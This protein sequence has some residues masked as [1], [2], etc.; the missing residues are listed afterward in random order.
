MEIPLLKEIVVVLGI[1]IFIILGFQKLKLPSILG[2]LLAGIIVGPS[3]FNLLSS[4]H[5]VELLSEIG[6]IFLLFVIGI[7]LSF[8]GLMKMRRIVFLGGGVQVIGTILLTSLVVYA[9][10]ISYNTAIFIGFLI[11][12]S[13]TA[14]VLKM[15]QERGEISQSHGRLALGILIFQDIIVVPMMLLTPILAGKSDDVTMTIIILI[16]KLV[17]LGVVVWILQKYIV[18]QVFKMVVKAKNRELFILTTIVFCFAIAWLTSAVGLSLALGAFFAGLIISESEYSHQATANVLP[19]REI[20]ISFFFISVGSLLDL[21]FFAENVLYILAFV[22]IVL[23]VKMIIIFVTSAV[24]KL[25]VKTAMMTALAVF[26]VGE[27]SLLLSTV[28]VQNDLLTQDM[29]QYFLA[30]SIMTMALTPFFI[31]KSDAL[32]AYFLKVPLPKRVRARIKAQKMALSSNEEDQDDNWDDHVVIIGY[33]INGKNIAR[34][35]RSTG[36]PYVIVEIDY[37]EIQEAKRRNH[38]VVYGDASEPEIL[39]YINIQKARTAVI[40]ISD[41]N[42]TKK[43]I[44]TIRL[45]S[46]TVHTIVRTRYVKEIEENMK[47][48]ADEVI[49]EEF[50]TSIEI[51]T[52]V[53]KQ[54][55]ITHDEINRIVSN[56]RSSDYEMLTSV[57]PFSAKGAFEQLNIPN[58]EVA[59]LHVQHKD[60]DI[61][62]KSLIESQLSQKYN[63]VV[64]GI[65]RGRYYKSEIKP[66]SKIEVDDIIYIFGAPKDINALNKVIKI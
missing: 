29:Y 21:S 34:V 63:L 7:E 24:L 46:Q 59:S 47:L 58:K 5:E 22:L 2:F 43:I 8:S 57:K 25:N 45:F 41:P 4:Y 16:A 19:F 53:L 37:D 6:I 52:R 65:K 35:T 11:A 13:S 50:E 17:G 10:G 33:G 27:F 64:L 38:P 1:S 23:L 49:P 31:Q 42:A 20:F 3:A 12:L 60:N 9:F 28:G 48:G 40:A 39:K 51:F 36:I 18:P 26:Q 15:L 55:M 14:I 54:Y 30:V 66:T 44:S 62:G 61:V 32:T 56:I